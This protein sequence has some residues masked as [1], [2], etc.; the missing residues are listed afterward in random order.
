MSSFVKRFTE[1]GLLMCPP[2]KIGPIQSGHINRFA[3]VNL[4]SEV[5]ISVNK[6]TAFVNQFCET[7]I[8]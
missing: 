3:S 8:S 2:S 5:D 1:A 7:D 6:M 4:F